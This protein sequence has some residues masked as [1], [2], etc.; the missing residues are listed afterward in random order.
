MYGHVKTAREQM[1]KHFEKLYASEI[2]NFTGY[3][4]IPTL[5]TRYSS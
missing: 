1:D 4:L 3:V 2:G 5:L